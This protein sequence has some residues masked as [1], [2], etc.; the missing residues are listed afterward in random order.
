[1]AR[2]MRT[3][4]LAD[5]L[6]RRGHSEVWWHSSFSHQTKELVSRDDCEFSIA[7]HFRLKLLYSGSYRRHLSLRRTLHHRRLAL[8]F[9]RVAALE[10]QR[11]AVVCALTPIGLASEA[12]AC[13]NQRGIPVLVDVRDPWPE[14]FVEFTPPGLRPVARLAL[15]PAFRKTGRLLSQ[16][17]G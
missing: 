2:P 11:D 3:G 8:K 6:T 10:R 4:L 15:R 7:A 16:A 9:R 17:S 1:G 12:V 14:V 5:E 13:A